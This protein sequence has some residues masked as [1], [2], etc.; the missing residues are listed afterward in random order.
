M[1][2]LDAKRF[3]SF[4]ALGLGARAWAV[5]LRIQIL[6]FRVCGVWS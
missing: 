4:W 1:T 6:G 3:T 2:A 5:K